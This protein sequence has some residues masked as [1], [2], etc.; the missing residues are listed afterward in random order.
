MRF[1]NQIWPSAILLILFSGNLHAQEDVIKAIN[2]YG[3]FDRWCSREVKESLVIGG[4]HKKLYEFYGDYTN[5]FTGDTPYTSPEG[6]LW[7]TNN[8]LAVV[9]G[10]VKTN[11]TVFPE[12]RGDG[13]CARIETHIEHVKVLGMINMDVVCQ[14]VMMLGILPEPI[15]TTKDPMSKVSYGIAFNDCPKAIEFDYKADVG[16]EVIRG[17]GFSK[18]QA[19][20]YNDAAEITCMLLNMWEEEDGSIHAL[21]VATGIERIWEDAPEWINGYRLN[22]HYGDITSEPFYQD[23]MGLKTNPKTAYRARNSKG[24]MVIIQEDGWA[25]IG[26]KPNHMMLHFITSCG[27]AFYGGVGNTLWLD[28]IKIIM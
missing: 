10:I 19:Q 27:E 21:R 20:G 2:D 13:F 22:L 28:N 23:F 17:T 7:R 12:K 24:E 9:L 3:T 6:Y 8:I 5:E 11:N 15:T 25:P 1:L 16:Y 4:K 18:L 14:G 26:T